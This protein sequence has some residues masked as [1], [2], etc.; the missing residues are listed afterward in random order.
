MSSVKVLSPSKLAHVVL[1]TGRFQ[2]MVD[3][4]KKFLGAKASYE[5]KFLSFLTYDEEHHRIAIV[6]K[7]GLNSRD[8]ETA[9]MEHMAFT[10]D[11]LEDLFQAYKQRLEIGI[12][13]VLC[14]NHGPTMSIYYADVDG[15]EIETQVDS[16][17]TAEAATKFMMGEAFDQN[18]IG[19]EF[20]PE[21]IMGRMAKGESVKSILKRPDTITGSKL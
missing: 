18:P 21:E 15:N 8:E 20:D 4:Y 1:R 2:E 17:D 11:K 13:P 6:F 16:F 19:V 5:N 12:K 14:I 9:G 10:Y 7:P 3:F